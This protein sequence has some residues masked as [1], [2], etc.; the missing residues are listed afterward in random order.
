MA[1]QMITL[2]FHSDCIF[3]LKHGSLMTTLSISSQNQNTEARHCPVPGQDGGPPEDCWLGMWS[4][5][6][7]RIFRVPC[8]YI[9]EWIERWWDV[10]PLSLTWTINGLSPQPRVVKW[11]STMH[12]IGEHTQFLP[13]RNF[14]L[15]CDWLKVVTWHSTNCGHIS[16]SL[17]WQS[18][19][20]L[21]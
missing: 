10:P 3:N 7:N 19:K 2:F 15:M 9:P 13:C 16:S 12:L 21:G 20:Q 11:F 1:L 8:Q 5:H 4:F 18:H 14:F 17:Q 6:L